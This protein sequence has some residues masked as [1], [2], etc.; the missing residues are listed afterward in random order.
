MPFRS[1]FVVVVPGAHLQL[2]LGFSDTGAE[3]WISVDHVVWGNS[4][5]WKQTYCAG[6]NI[7][8]DQDVR[9]L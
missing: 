6:I 9:I 8:I 2:E 1:P 7:E 3:A 5:P 4:T